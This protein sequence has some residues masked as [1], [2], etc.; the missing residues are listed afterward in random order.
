M[1]LDLHEHTETRDRDKR[2]I[3]RDRHYRESKCFVGGK[4]KKE[5]VN[6]HLLVSHVP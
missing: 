2:Q 1:V 3:M 4:K 5:S 6:D